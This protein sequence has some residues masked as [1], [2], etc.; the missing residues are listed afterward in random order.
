MSWEGKHLL[1]LFFSAVLHDLVIGRK[2]LNE[3]S[4]RSLSSG[5]VFERKLENFVA[6]VC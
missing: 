2:G 6:P 4:E 3:G 5:A 1:T